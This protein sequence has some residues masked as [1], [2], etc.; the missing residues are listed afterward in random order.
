VGKLP[1]HL[2]GENAVLAEDVCTALSRAIEKFT[3]HSGKLLR[4]LKS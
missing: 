2:L 1:A 3:N 4:P